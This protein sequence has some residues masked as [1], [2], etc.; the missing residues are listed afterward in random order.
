MME[1]YL[2]RNI[3]WWPLWEFNSEWFSFLLKSCC[4]VLCFFFKTISLLS[5]SSSK[6]LYLNIFYLSIHHF[7]ALLI[8]FVFCILICKKFILVNYVVYLVFFCYAALFIRVRW[9]GFCVYC[10]G[11]VKNFFGCGWL[12]LKQIA[13]TGNIDKFA[14]LAR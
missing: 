13:L 2:G 11:K 14:I 8:C 10:A 4:V 3:L 6:L 9:S 7:I 12:F 1:R 5:T